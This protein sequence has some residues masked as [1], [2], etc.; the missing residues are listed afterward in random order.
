VKHISQLVHDAEAITVSLLD[1]CQR[2]VQGKGLMRLAQD[3]R[4]PRLL[5]D[6]CAVVVP[7]QKALMAAIPVVSGTPLKKHRA[8]PNDSITIAGFEDEVLVL[9]SLQRPRKLVIRGSDG[10][11]YPILCK[12]KDDLRKD[13]RLMEFNAMIDRALRRDVEASK[14]KLYIKTYAVTTLNDEH[15]VL[16]WV[17]GLKPLRDIIIGQLAKVGIRPNFGEAKQVLDRACADGERAHEIFLKELLPSVPPVLHKWFTE[18]FPEPD[19]WF[20]ARLRY[21]RSCAVMSIVGNALGLGD[22][23]GENISLEQGAGGV[24]HVDFNCLF[25]KGLTFDKPETVPFRL[26]HNMVD[27]FGAYE[28]E[29]PFRKAAEITQRTLRQYEDTLMT[30]MEA[31]VHDPTTD[32]GFERR[33][34]VP[35]VPET[36]AEVLASVRSKFGCMLPGETVP[37]SVEGYVDALVRAA[38]DPR[39]LVRMYVGWCPFL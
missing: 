14:R 30:I 5:N 32:F 37:L 19:L 24:F 12:P 8:F 31:F 4:F 39:N 20:G 25:Q 11:K 27:A 15:G 38:V 9:S 28:Y 1:I 29:G 36:P 7:V 33:R 21:T 2:Q 3:L 16:E 22:R 6:P 10:Q 13:Q 35:G 18:Q 26:T 23:H 34:K 17:D